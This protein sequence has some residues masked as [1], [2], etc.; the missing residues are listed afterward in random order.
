MG[1]GNGRGEGRGLARQRV[2]SGS[3]WGATVGYS[4]AVRAGDLVFVAGTTAAGS[5]GS[6]SVGDDAAAQTRESI[7]RIAAA[8]AECGARLADVVCTRMYVTDV[9]RWEE[10]GRAHGERFGDIRPAAT[11]VEVSG[12]IDPT[13]LVE[14]EAVAVAAPVV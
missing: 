7:D 11:M 12:L 4:R 3:R 9:S 14:I 2:D 1:M 13:L 6:S 10:I 5:D 8:L